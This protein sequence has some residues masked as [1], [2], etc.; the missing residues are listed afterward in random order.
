MGYVSGLFETPRTS[1]GALENIPL[2]G[3]LGL[4]KSY[5]SVIQYPAHLGVS[6]PSLRQMDSL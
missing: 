4:G 5:H 3:N 1:L 6:K 2:T